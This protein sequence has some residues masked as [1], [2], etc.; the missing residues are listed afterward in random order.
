VRDTPPDVQQGEYGFEPAA[1]SNFDKP[2]DADDRMPDDVA[3]NLGREADRSSTTWLNA[4]RRAA[5]NNSSRAFQS[6]HPQGSKYIS[7][8]YTHRSTLY[9]PKT[10]AMVRRDEAATA[11]AFFAN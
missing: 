5:W 1:V 3:I 11:A 6:L 9:R 4:S 2:G 10:R 7:S 8:S